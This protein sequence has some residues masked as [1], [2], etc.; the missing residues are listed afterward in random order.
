MQHAGSSSCSD[1][2]AAQAAAPSRETALLDAVEERAQWSIAMGVVAGLAG[3]LLLAGLS[4]S[5]VGVV[6]AG[7]AVIGSP[8]VLLVSNR[9][10]RRGKQSLGIY[11][12]LMVFWLV[13]QPLVHHEGVGQVGQILGWVGL[14]FCPAGLYGGWSALRLLPAARDALTAPVL[15]ARLE[16]TLHR[17]YGGLPYTTAQLWPADPATPLVLARFRSQYSAPRLIAADKLPAKIHGTPNRGQVVVV[18][19]EQAV[20]VGRI[21]RSHFGEEHV[22]RRTPP[23]IAW[24]IKPRSLRP[25]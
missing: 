10:E 16:I 17:G 12:A 8:L 14:I 3:V 22:P 13:A 2:S 20:L 7:A 11:A 23:L 21:G 25:R 5:A 6:F 24:L 18:S 9:T 4:S 19:C 15:D 1:P